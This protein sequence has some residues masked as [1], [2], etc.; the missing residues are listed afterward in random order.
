VK[1]LQRTTEGIAGDGRW[2]GAVLRLCALAVGSVFFSMVKGH[3]AGDSYVKS[4]LLGLAATL[5]FSVPFALWRFLEL[6]REKHR[7]RQKAIR[8]LDLG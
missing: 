6:R 7:R 8:P 2:A 5:V 4:L 3:W 1:S